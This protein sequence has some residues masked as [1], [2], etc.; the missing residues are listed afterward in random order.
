MLNMTSLRV[1]AR[2]QDSSWTL[3]R[4]CVGWYTCIR[5]TIYLAPSLSSCC[6]NRALS[7]I[8]WGKLYWI[9]KSGC[10]RDQDPS[11]I[12]DRS[13]M[14]AER[15]EG[16][17]FETQKETRNNYRSVSR[18]WRS[19]P[20]LLLYASKVQLIRWML[21]NFRALK[22]HGISNHRCSPIHASASMEY[23][24]AKTPLHRAL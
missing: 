5:G 19:D 22:L 3:G 17:G 12:Q 23:S 10:R 1:I 20:V 2:R 6:Q 21:I 24:I 14:T 8:G 4:D 15:I 11:V 18:S 16:E 9:L 7:Q 13:S